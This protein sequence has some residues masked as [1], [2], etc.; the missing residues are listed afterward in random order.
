MTINI[1]GANGTKLS[2][3]TENKI[4][5]RF[6]DFEDEYNL[7]NSKYLAECNSDIINK[8][9]YYHYLKQISNLFIKSLSTGNNSDNTNDN[10]NNNNRIQHLVEYTNE[11]N[12]LNT[13][14]PHVK[15]VF[16]EFN[17]LYHLHNSLNLINDKLNGV[18]S[19]TNLS[20][21]RVTPHVKKFVKNI[22]NV[23]QILKDKYPDNEEFNKHIED[24]QNILIQIKDEIKKLKDILLEHKHK[25]QIEDYN[26]SQISSDFVANLKISLDDIIEVNKQIND[27]IKELINLINKLTDILSIIYTLI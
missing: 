22:N 11:R 19:S 20:S 13:L 21:V 27:N 12:L 25:I 8:K 15:H 7:L 14:Y 16:K 24:I 1:I 6:K 5:N 9:C 26:P 2:L 17:I 18:D 4:E 3:I 10:N 23:I